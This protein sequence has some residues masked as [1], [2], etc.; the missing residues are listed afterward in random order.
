MAEATIPSDGN[1]SVIGSTIQNFINTNSDLDSI[2]LAASSGGIGETV[3]STLSQMN[4]KGKVSF[5]CFDVFEDV[6]GA[7][8]EGYL[9]AACGGQTPQAL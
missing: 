3:V 9:S 1:N 2:I 6:R 7:F 5:A 8:E 4:V